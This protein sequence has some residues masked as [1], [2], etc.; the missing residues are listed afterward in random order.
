M[1]YITLL[2]C[3]ACQ[4]CTPIHHTTYPNSYT[5]IIEPSES[6]ALIAEEMD[7][8]A[9]Y[10]VA[11]GPLPENKP[12]I[13]DTLRIVSDAGSFGPSYLVFD[14]PKSQGTAI[15]GSLRLQIERADNM[16]SDRTARFPVV[17]HDVV[18]LPTYLDCRGI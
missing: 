18:D 1:R 11:D 6:A 15:F 8:F 14:L 17:L 2:T 9:E 13:P 16:N 12:V 4:S 3:L 10:S 7:A 5:C